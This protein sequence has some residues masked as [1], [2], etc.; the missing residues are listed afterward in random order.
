MDRGAR[1]AT[2]SMGSQKQLAM[3]TER[4]SVRIST[5]FFHCFELLFSLLLKVEENSMS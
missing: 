2:V 4:L 1:R 3:T 5:G